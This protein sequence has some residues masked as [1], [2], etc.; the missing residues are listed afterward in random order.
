[1]DKEKW[2]KIRFIAKSGSIFFH[3]VCLLGNGENYR[4]GL[5]FCEIAAKS[6]FLKLQI[7]K[8]LNEF[9]EQFVRS[10]VKSGKYVLNYLLQLKQ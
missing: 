4:M 5:F 9:N 7:N 2:I 1:M 10:V 8:N 3:F 6:S